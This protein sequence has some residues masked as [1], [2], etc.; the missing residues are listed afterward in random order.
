MNNLMEYRLADA[1][2]SATQRE[3]IGLSMIEVLM[4]QTLPDKSNHR[5]SSTYMMMERLIIWQ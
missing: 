1:F 4:S 2:P 5:Q 3:S